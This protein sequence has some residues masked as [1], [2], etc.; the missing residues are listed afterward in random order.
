MWR[1]RLAERVRAVKSAATRLAALGPD[2]PLLTARPRS[3]FLAVKVARRAGCPE[4]SQHP[5]WVQGVAGHPLGSGNVDAVTGRAGDRDRDVLLSGAVAREL[6]RHA[7]LPAAPHDAAPGASERADRAL[8][9]VPASD[10]P[11]VD[12]LRPGVPVTATVSKCAE[13][14]TQ[15]LVA[16]PAEA[17]D[18]VLARL[19]RHGRLAGVA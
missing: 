17:S 5:G 18:L 13:R 2:R 12:R 11:D 4:Q 8:V 7:V 14:V 16:R 6:V 10:R 3:A 9:I 15:P 19:D 1:Y